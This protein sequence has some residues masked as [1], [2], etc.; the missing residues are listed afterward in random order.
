MN[1]DYINIPKCLRV[2]KNDKKIKIFSTR[3]L[4]IKKEIKIYIKF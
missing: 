1:I 3:Y 2:S 4:R